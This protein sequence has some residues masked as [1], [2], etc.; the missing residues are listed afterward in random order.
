MYRDKQSELAARE[1]QAR[2][3]GLDGGLQQGELTRL[4]QLLPHQ[5]APDAK[6]LQ[7]KTAV[8]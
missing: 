7:N 5:H 1:Q 3:Y 6:H 2:W 4:A 8:N